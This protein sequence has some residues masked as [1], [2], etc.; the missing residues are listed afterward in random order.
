MCSS[1][2][3][4]VTGALDWIKEK[5]EAFTGW[6]SDAWDGLTSLFFE[7][8]FTGALRDAFGWEEDNAFVNGIL[9]VRDVLTGIPDLI[10][11]I[12]DILFKGDFSGMPFGLE[13]DS[14]FVNFLFNVRD[15]VISAGDFIKKVFDGI[16][17]VAKVTLAVISTVILTPLLLAWQALSW[18]INAAWENIIKPAWDGLSDGITWIW[19]NVLSPTFT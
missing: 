4:A 13:E 6:I 15:A 14:G 12:T 16:W 8:D 11:G 17:Q 19:E 2:L 9:T 10:T 18:G 5:F 7:G 1:D 3:D